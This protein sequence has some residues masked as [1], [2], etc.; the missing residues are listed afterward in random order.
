M[1]TTG[2]GSTGLKASGTTGTGYEDSDSVE[3]IVIAAGD[4]LTVTDGATGALLDGTSATTE[5]VVNDGTVDVS[6]EGSVGIEASGTNADAQNVAGFYTVSSGATGLLASNNGSVSN[7]GEIDISGAGTVGMKADYADSTATNNGTID[8]STGGSETDKLVGMY[9]VDG[10]T[11]EN[12]QALDID[13][14]YSVGMKVEDDSSVLNN[15]GNISVSGDNSDGILVVNK[16]NLS[17]V[18]GAVIV[19]GKNSSGIHADNSTLTTNDTD[20]NVSFAD[21]A[22]NSSLILSDNGSVVTNTGAMNVTVSV[23]EIDQ[24]NAGIKITGSDSEGNN[25]GTIKVGSYNTGMI[26]ENGGTAVNDAT[27][28]INMASSTGRGMLAD[29]SGS[30]ATNKGIIA[31]SIDGS[32]TETPIGIEAVDGGTGINEAT[33]DISAAYAIGMK[34][35]D[36]TI[37]NTDTINVTGSESIGMTATGTSKIGNEGT[38]NVNTGEGATGIYIDG[39]GTESQVVTFS[40]GTDGTINVAGNDSGNNETGIKLEGSNAYVSSGSVGTINV[41]SD[42]ATGILLQEGAELGSD[43][44]SI[45]GTIKV[46]DGSAAGGNVGIKAETGSKV[47]F[48]GDVNLTAAIDG[49]NIG[50]YAEDS[51]GAENNTYIENSGTITMGSDNTTIAM[52]GSGS[53][54]TVVNNGIIEIEG[55]SSTA[56][57]IEKGAKGVN[58]QGTLNIDEDNS[59]GMEITAATGENNGEINVISNNST[60]IKLSGIGSILNQGS[61][62]HIYV[63]GETSDDGS[64]S[65]TADNSTGIYVDGITLGTDS[66]VEGIITIEGTDN[67]TGI[68][69][70]NGSVMTYS[71][72]MTV[73]TYGDEINGVGNSQ[74]VKVTSNSEFIN[75]GT[76]TVNDTDNKGIYVDSSSEATN[77]GKINVSGN[78]SYGLYGEAGASLTNASEGTINVSGG[79]S[80]ESFGMYMDG[81][82]SATDVVSLSNDGTINLSG[83]GAIALG[84]TVTNY[85]LIQ[86]GSA[87]VEDHNAGSGTYQNNG[88]INVGSDSKVGIFGDLN[89]TVINIGTVN[90]NTENTTGLYS[91]LGDISN[92]GDIISSENGNTGISLIGASNE[93]VNDGSIVLAGNSSIGVYVSGGANVQNNDLIEIGDTTDTSAG[94]S[95]YGIKAESNSTVSSE[96][97]ANI[98]MYG[99]SSYGISGDGTTTIENNGSIEMGY[100]ELVGE[101]FVYTGGDSSYG[102]YSKTGDSVTNTG[103]ITMYG[104]SAVGMY[105]DGDSDISNEGTV[106]VYGDETKAIASSGTGNTLT[107]NEIINVKGSLVK[108]DE[109][110]TVYFDKNN[111]YEMKLVDNELISITD[112]TLIYTIDKS[113]NLYDSDENLLGN[114]N[115]GYDTGIVSFK[116][117]TYGIYVEDQQTGDNTDTIY[118]GRANADDSDEGLTGTAYGIYVK[119]DGTVTESA[120]GTNAGDILVNGDTDAGMVADSVDSLIQNSGNIEVVTDEDR[121]SQSYMDQFKDE[122][123]TETYGMKVNEGTGENSGNI[124]V[125]TESDI[126]ILEGRGADGEGKTKEL[127]IKNIGY[128]VYTSGSTSEGTSSGTI[129][130]NSDYSYGMYSTEES[131]VTNSGTINVQGVSDSYGM[132]SDKGSEAL[133]TGVINIGDSSDTDNAQESY[134]MYATS[135]TGGTAGGTLINEGSIEVASGS[136]GSHSNYGIYVDD[137]GSNISNTVENRS[138]INV[139]GDNSYGI[140]LENTGTLYGDSADLN[141]YEGYDGTGSDTEE[142]NL[143]QGTD[144]IVVTGEDSVGIHVNNNSVL[145][146]N[147]AGEVDYDNTDDI[148]SDTDRTH[149]AGATGSSVIINTYDRTTDGIGGQ[150]R[151]FG[152]K[153]DDDTYTVDMDGDGIQDDTILA[154]AIMVTGNKDEWGDI[155]VDDSSK[156]IN[157]GVLTVNEVNGVGI[158]ANEAFVQNFTAVSTGTGVT[159]DDVFEMS[160]VNGSVVESFVNRNGSFGVT[161]DINDTTQDIYIDDSSTA[162]NSGSIDLTGSAAGTNGVEANGNIVVGNYGE[163]KDDDTSD[164]FSL[165]GING[166]TVISGTSFDT[167][168]EGSL[169]ITGS[170]SDSGAVNDIYVDSTSMG[171]N[172]GTINVSSGD[173]GVTVKDGSSFENSMGSDYSKDE[174]LPLYDKQGIINVTGDDSIGIYLEGKEASYVNNGEINV[175]G[176]I[177]T[178]GNRSF[179]VYHEGASSMSNDGTITLSG[180]GSFAFA[181]S[182]DEMGQQTETMPDTE[183]S[184][185]NNGTIVVQG[186]AKY[187]L[188]GDSNDG[189]TNGGSITVN[190]DG[191][192]YGIYQ[193]DVSEITNNGNI[194]L[195]SST[196]MA[197]GTDDR[198]GTREVT[199]TNMS[200]GTVTVEDNALYGMY[201]DSNDTLS[202]EGEVIVKNTGTALYKE[203]N[204]SGVTLENDGIISLYNTDS[205][206]FGTT[207]AESEVDNFQNEGTINVGSEDEGDAI[208]GILGDTNDIIVNNGTVNVVSDNA[209]ALYSEGSTQTGTADSPVVITNDGEIV[210]TGKD[211]TSFGSNQDYEKFV[212]SASGTIDVH[213]EVENEVAYGMYS[214]KAGSTSE[215]SGTI[216]VNPDV[217]YQEYGYT[218]DMGTDDTSDDEFVVVG[219]SNIETGSGVG[220]YAGNSATVTN[221]SSGVINVYG[222]DSSGM[223]AVN[224]TLINEGEIVADINYSGYEKD[225]LKT[226]MS[227]TDNSTLINTGKIILDDTSSLPTDQTVVHSAYGM[228]VEDSSTAL[229]QGY[230]QV[231]NNSAGMYAKDS[232]LAYTG[233]D[234]NSDITDI[235]AVASITNDTYVDTTGDGYSEDDK[236]LIMITG[237]PG[238]TGDSLEDAVGMVADNALALNKGVIVID[239]TADNSV[240]MKVENNGIIV[241]TGDIVINSESSDSEAFGNTDGTDVTAIDVGLVNGT[242][243]NYGT[244]S[245]RR[246]GGFGVLSAMSGSN[247]VNYGTLSSEGVLNIQTDS[248]SAFVIATDQ[249]GALGTIE[250]DIVVV[251]GNVELDN[252]YMSQA[253]RSSY[254]LDL[255]ISGDTDGLEENISLQNSLYRIA[256]VSTTVTSDSSSDTVINISKVPYSQL[257]PYEDQQAYGDLLDAAIRRDEINGV[258]SQEQLDIANSILEDSENLDIG[259]QN[260]LQQVMGGTYTN[261][262]EIYYQNKNF[263]DVLVKDLI[264][265]DESYLAGNFGTQ[266]LVID[267]KDDGLKLVVKRGSDINI[268]DKQG[269]YEVE[270]DIIGFVVGN[271]WKEYETGATRVRKGI[272]V[273]YQNSQLEYDDPGN[274]EGSGNLLNAGAYYLYDKPEWQLRT[275]LSISYGSYEIERSISAAYIEESAETDIDTYGIS[276]D[277]EYSR[278]YEIKNYNLIPYLGLDL[279]KI[280]QNSFEEIGAGEYSVDGKSKEID[281][282]EGTL[283]IRSGKRYGINEKLTLSLFTSVEYNYQFSDRYETQQELSSNLVDSKY[284]LAEADDSEAGSFR[285]SISL[286]IDVSNSFSVI[287]S[288]SIDDRGNDEAGL[289]LRYEF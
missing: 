33:F 21:G 44:E 263:Y 97:G 156:F 29:G 288:Y 171:A 219:S 230:I 218:D 69:L 41:S 32:T 260:I 278:V 172:L 287:G 18:G 224:G 271:E 141:G 205:Y 82:D 250:A 129:D 147:T 152:T 98:R 104:D 169:V 215:N 160:G 2:S 125:A 134:G 182:L 123:V 107:N 233:I 281:S 241:N 40:S 280:Y 183:M 181:S 119:G 89:D 92:T 176:G 284:K 234:E 31:M 138:K 12:T 77:K 28:T 140:Y 259:T 22:E 108:D 67:T 45:A 210:L 228:Y 188:W 100:G 61:E 95:S 72:D 99:D 216:N 126:M 14:D 58:N 229:N 192:G 148:Y 24:S 17:S 30:T 154:N 52:K 251:E 93:A 132:Y 47:Y 113:G 264:Y 74:S 60:G 212:N 111:G 195:K 189:L 236:G 7:S 269:S 130:V 166:A 135:A 64:V 110:N 122:I 161:D 175:S 213:T 221:T 53:G 118:V 179:A 285:Y 73:S 78:G 272:L 193:L 270:N 117:T 261:L 235:E 96:T 239:S 248:D 174:D 9:A 11:I 155:Y 153:N 27:G 196:A 23:D 256:G 50:F 265:A 199:Y 194:T 94:G 253:L 276:L 191:E 46:A 116:N 186:N 243:V 124:L 80:A 63:G 168:S 214:D 258:A 197:M 81:A 240:G 283:G 226:A 5:L 127:G 170:V 225:V 79:S 282:A 252:G 20:F 85:D 203:S 217:Y 246:A 106:T 59:V 145:V 37:N 244:V 102:I 39:T 55:E 66:I 190:T 42:G 76:L 112:D 206:S 178:D 209:Y 177:D 242:V 268:E 249:E 75:E 279:T 62:G 149:E 91:I 90:L 274:S 198:D 245:L 231:G 1:T 289:I 139:T 4:T 56:M 146:L 151:D 26:A 223:S 247:F 143:T 222:K 8:F 101:N 6:G 167:D 131:T 173:K 49:E 120:T 36:S 262:S 266:K 48:G 71:G 86:S 227:G 65:Y 84:S 34:A 185:S 105:R 87:A 275:A 254:S 207:S 158:W 150:S 109:G 137:N 38:I 15:S 51:T 25:Q 157:S 277:T 128:G 19:S 267:T 201:A 164:S 88:T 200:S 204:G 144:S 57:V 208:Y 133:N 83:E 273:G 211:S 162:I 35:E 159:S 187:G 115:D 43:S 3:E 255:G 114:I 54:A 220:M 13:S 202:N 10:G 237:N 70:D 121:L 103:N 68:H 257:T 238:S 180:E 142:N 184:Y 165:Y 286:G 16:N 232:T 136:V 163:I